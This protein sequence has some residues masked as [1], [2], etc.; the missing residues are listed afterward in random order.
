VQLGLQP[1][2]APSIV[3]C[4]RISKGGCGQSHETQAPAS[5]SVNWIVRCPE[6]HLILPHLC[7]HNSEGQDGGRQKTSHEQ[8]QGSRQV[9]ERSICAEQGRWEEGEGQQHNMSTVARLRALRRRGRG[10]LG[11]A[12][13]HATWFKVSAAHAYSSTLSC[14]QGATPCLRH[15][16]EA[17]VEKGETSPPQMSAAH[18][19]RKPHSAAFIAARE[20]MHA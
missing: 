12:A 11:T 15:R 19:E 9:V 7:L 8:R 2:S 4:T 6:T 14:R 13:K 1:R 16:L 3:P 18:A 17:D 20:A 5:Q 10:E